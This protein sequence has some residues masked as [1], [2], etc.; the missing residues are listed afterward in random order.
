MSVFQSL[1]QRLIGLGIPSFNIA[2]YRIEPIV[3][4]GFL[5]TMLFFGLPG[6]VFAALLFGV[7]MM[8]GGGDNNG[9]SGSGNGAQ[10]RHRAGR[11]LRHR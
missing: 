5:L 11:V 2:S 9:D 3:T 6:L 8:S 1:N 10:H 7:V 4:V